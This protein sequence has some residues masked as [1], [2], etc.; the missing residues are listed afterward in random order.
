MIQCV[1]IAV[2]VFF[3]LAAAGPVF[4]DQSRGQRSGSGL[5]SLNPGEEGRLS[6]AAPNRN[7]Q[8][9]FTSPSQAGTGNTPEGQVSSFHT[10]V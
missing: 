1:L 3:P 8:D 10:C 7:A 9:L 4:E 2:V 5:M 6:Q